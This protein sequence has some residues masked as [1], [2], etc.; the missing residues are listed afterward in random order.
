LIK[1]KNR[2]QKNTEEGT[3][4]NCRTAVAFKRFVIAIEGPRVSAYFMNAL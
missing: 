4:P 3:A 2:D 1:K